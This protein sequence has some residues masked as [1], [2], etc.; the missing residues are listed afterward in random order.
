MNSVNRM[1]QAI[2]QCKKIQCSK[3]DTSWD[4]SC[5]KSYAF[6]I[7]G[8]RQPPR[9]QESFGEKS[10]SNTFSSRHGK[11]SADPSQSGLQLVSCKLQNPRWWCWSSCSN[12]VW[13][14][15]RENLSTTVAGCDVAIWHW[16]TS[17][18]DTQPN[19]TARAKKNN[20]PI[21]WLSIDSWSSAHI[22]TPMA[23]RFEYI[24]QICSC[25]QSCLSGVSYFRRAAI[26]GVAPSRLQ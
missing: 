2:K 4:F 26:Q 16:D 13:L 20:F 7:F 10:A 1:K 8:C 25:L 11:E 3:V 17:C 22:S 9:C 14:E 12:Q 19:R 23:S 18:R 6:W 21:P 5:L 24:N 15:W